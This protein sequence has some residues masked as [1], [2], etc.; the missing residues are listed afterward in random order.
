M[1]QGRGGG[2]VREA[3]WQGILFYTSPYESIKH[4]PNYCLIKRF[5]T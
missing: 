4:P 2:G 1:E 5:G 3:A